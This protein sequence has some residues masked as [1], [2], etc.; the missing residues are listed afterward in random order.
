MAAVSTSPP[1]TAVSPTSNYQDSRQ[2]DDT[3]RSPVRVPNLNLANGPQLRQAPVS[4]VRVNFQEENWA[5]PSNADIE[6][7]Q[8]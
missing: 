1:P 5:Q 2:S 7:A 4:P 6:H 8:R 3:P